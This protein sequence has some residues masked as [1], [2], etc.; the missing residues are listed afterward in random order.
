MV[1]NARIGIAMQPNRWFCAVMARKPPFTVDLTDD[2]RAALER[3]RIKLG[4]RSAA[5]AIRKL[6]EENDPRID[7]EFLRRARSAAVTA[8]IATVKALS[9][10]PLPTIARKTS[11]KGGERE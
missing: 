10:K 6:I 4:A 8:G 3:V 5:D 11:P 9:A 2:A 1:V 7:P